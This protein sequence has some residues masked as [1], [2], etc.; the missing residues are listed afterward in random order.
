MH[1]VLQ[2]VFCITKDYVDRNTLIGLSQLLKVH[3]HNIH[4]SP[5][6][7]KLFRSFEIIP[8]SLFRIQR[9]YSLL[10]AIEG[11]LDLWSISISTLHL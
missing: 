9:W 1:L 2:Y 4:S 8:R 3:W 7:K 11:H 10:S 6:D 5:R